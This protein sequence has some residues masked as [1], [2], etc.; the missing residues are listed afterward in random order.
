MSIIYFLLILGVIILIHELGHLLTAK[1]FKVYCHEFSFGFGPKLISKQGKETVYSIRAFPFGGFVR[2]AGEEKLEGDVDVPQER[3]L[4]GI[5]PYKRII[6][7]LSGIGMNI[8]LAIT[9]FAIL[10]TMIGYYVKFP[11]PVIAEVTAN[12]P[13]QEA[14]VL[15]GD[16]II[17]VTFSDGVVI[18]PDTF[19][20]IVQYL[21]AY[22][23]EAYYILERNNQQLTVTMT[24]E[25]DQQQDR[26]MLGI[27]MNDILYLPVTSVNAIY[28]GGIYTM[29]MAKEI[30]SSLGNLIQGRGL[31]NLSGPVAIFQMTGETMSSAE[32]LKEGVFYFLNIVAFL[33]LNVGIF[34]LMP[35]PM[36]DGG[37]VMLTTIEIIIGKPLNKNIEYALI[38]A[39]AVLIMMLFVFI[40][41]N[42]IVKLFN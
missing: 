30:F 41:W 14:G 12:S 6:I 17:Q 40:I 28:Y 27:S 34:N 5:S 9:F 10:L 2:M 35:I 23:D 29:D 33:S 25:Y 3:T 37:R 8:I 39:S 42:D 31:K 22:N 15:A 24:P 18:K 36:L 4:N 19:S 11:E 21:Q 7:M 20:T 26:Y 16:K 13:A 1:L 32:S 38:N